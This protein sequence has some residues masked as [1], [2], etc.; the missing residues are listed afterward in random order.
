MVHS[1]N[2][3]PRLGIIASVGLIDYTYLNIK[4]GVDIRHILLHGSDGGSRYR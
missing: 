4:L 3:V 2:S 1:D